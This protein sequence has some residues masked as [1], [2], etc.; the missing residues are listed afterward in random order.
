MERHTKLRR[1]SGL[2]D[3]PF[4]KPVHLEGLV[5]II[6][7]AIPEALVFACFFTD[8]VCAGFMTAVVSPFS[9]L[10]AIRDSRQRG[11]HAVEH[12]LTGA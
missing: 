7:T 5:F 4:Y 3:F 6:A 1:I 12:K 8:R 11:R 2:R 10:L 9:R